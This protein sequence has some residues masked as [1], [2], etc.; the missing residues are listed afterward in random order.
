MP[1]ILGFFGAPGQMELIILVV[2]GLSAVGGFIFFSLAVRSILKSDT[3]ETPSQTE[4]S[5]QP[6]TADEPE[7]NAFGAYRPWE[8]TTHQ[9]QQSHP[10]P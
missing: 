1:A 8:K 4:T 9:N 7:E 6:D 3:P 5:S 10:N 2:T